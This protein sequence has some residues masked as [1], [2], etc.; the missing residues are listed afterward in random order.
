MEQTSSPLPDYD[1]PP[2]AEVVF[3]I[4]FNELEAIKVPHMGLLW[5]RFGRHEY[6]ECEEMPPLPT[7]M[8][9]FGGPPV[10]AAPISVE[11]VS[12]LPP[13]RLFFINAVK[14]HLIQV[15]QNRFLQNWRK[16]K[17]D[18]KYPRYAE[19]YPKFMKSWELFSSF[20]DD[21]NLGKL[22][23]NQYELT[24]VNHIPRGEGW[25]NLADIEQVFPEFQC[26]VGERFLPEPENVS[27]RKTYRFRKEAGRLHASLRLVVSRELKERMMV[28]DLTARGFVTGRMETWFDMAHEWIVR[29]FADLTG[30]SVQDLVWKK[31]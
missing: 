17:P 26:K 10:E 7:V 6:P 16:L 14:N 13:P 18:D 31:K 22:E 25:V 27:W 8:E 30:A 2:V 19:L 20:V 29:G 21:L 12:H 23:P 15:Q 11:Q 4:Q 1:N 3:G 5:E 24:Y 28:F 9:S